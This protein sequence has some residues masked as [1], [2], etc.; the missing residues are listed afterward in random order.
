MAEAT[1]SKPA[2]GPRVTSLS[3]IHFDGDDN[4]TFQYSGPSLHYPYSGYCLAM[5]LNEDGDIIKIPGCESD[6]YGRYKF[7]FDNEK[8]QVTIPDSYQLGL[9]DKTFTLVCGPTGSNT[10][11][12]VYGTTSQVVNGQAGTVSDSSVSGI[13]V[14]PYGDNANVQCRVH[15][16][17]LELNS[18]E[19]A[20][21]TGEVY[22]IVTERSEGFHNNTYD[23]TKNTNAL[24]ELKLKISPDDNG[25][26]TIELDGSLVANHEYIVG[27]YLNSTYRCVAWYTINT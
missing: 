6:K 3:N 22:L 15:L 24:G 2:L 13:S 14:T 18:P 1:L 10:D 26:Q 4:L 16:P 11:A 12:V 27:L 20:P 7:A 17:Y 19:S 25:T 8:S 9:L 23:G 21:A 5:L